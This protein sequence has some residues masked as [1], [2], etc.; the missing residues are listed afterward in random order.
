MLMTK[1]RVDELAAAGLFRRPFWWAR[2][3]LV[4]VSAC[5]LLVAV[6]VNPFR[7]MMSH[8]DGFAYARSVEHLIRTG[9]YQLDAWSAASMP[10]QIY[11]AAM[12]SKIFGYSLS[13][14]RLTTVGM[15]AQA[16][17]ASTGSPVTSAQP[18]R[19]VWLQPSLCWRA[20]WS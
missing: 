14:T 16:S 10:V 6:I 20:R 5:L 19:R 17:P 15:L 4:G 13:L 3:P 18:A 11:L 8:D 12:F 1:R 9:E 2:A 7:E